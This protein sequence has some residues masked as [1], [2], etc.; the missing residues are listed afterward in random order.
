MEKPAAKRKYLIPLCLL[1]SVLLVL[2]CVTLVKRLFSKQQTASSAAP[3]S[4]TLDFYMFNVGQGEAVLALCPDGSTLLLDCGPESG[5]RGL[6]NA[7][8][9][10]G[11]R[12]IDTLLISHNHSDH[13]G[14]LY[15]LL[16]NIPVGEALL[17]GDA[18]Y[19]SSVTKILAKKSTAYRFVTEGAALSVPDSVQAELFNPPAHTG[20][21][22]END[23]SA[24]IRFTF[25]Q[26]SLL[27]AG[28]AAYEA[29]SRILALYA[30][31]RLK[32]DVLL[33]GHHGASSSSSLSFLKAVSPKIACISVGA[34]N[35]YG[36][37]H[38][39][40]LRRLSLVGAEVY[41]TASHGTVHLL[42]DG[43]SVKVIE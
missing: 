35:D 31:S 10:L 5:A 19:Y 27:F 32:S 37:P 36:H 14:G 23:L 15:Y 11:I 41:T 42:L 39:D 22:D 8:K 3:V 29:E 6:V 33:V 38:A 25:G 34:G 1:L 16:K 7:L 9:A 24:V 17:A 28:D 18:S 43:S 20:A 21:E 30:R 2:C 4:G 13:T 12:K 26:T 40:T